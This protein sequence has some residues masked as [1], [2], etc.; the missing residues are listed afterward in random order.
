[1][2]TILPE[3]RNHTICF[4]NS[5]LLA[6]WSIYDR[7][8]IFNFFLYEFLFPQKIYDTVDDVSFESVFYSLKEIHFRLNEKD[9]LFGIKRML[10]NNAKLSN[11]LSCVQMREWNKAFQSFNEILDKNLLNNGM[12]N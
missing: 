1:M 5:K 6:S 8:I 3:S 9:Y 4:K 11:A 12:N 2:S 10:T 7:S